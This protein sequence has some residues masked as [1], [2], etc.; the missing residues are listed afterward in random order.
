MIKSEEIKIELNRGQKAELVKEFGSSFQS[1]RD[2]ITYKRSTPLHRAIRLRAIEMMNE[3][4]KQH[5]ITLK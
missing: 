4:Y 5:N 1:V 3:F 2:A